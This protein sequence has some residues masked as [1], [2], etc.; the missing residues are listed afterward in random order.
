MKRLFWYGFLAACLWV[1]SS[2][3]EAPGD[4]A[5]E[6]DTSN[7]PDAGLPPQGDVDGSADA[8]GNEFDNADAVD[9]IDASLG[10][11][12][13]AAGPYGVEEGDTIADLSFVLSDGGEF[14][15]GELYNDPDAKLLLLSTTAG[16]CT[17]CI[18]EQPELQALHLAHKDQGLV[19][20]V[21][22]F[23]DIQYQPAGPSHAKQWKEAYGLDFRVVADTDFELSAY[24]DTSLTPMNMFVDL[25]TMEIIKITTGWNPTL[26]DAIINLKL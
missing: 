10:G 20:I 3:A 18:E 1:G 15:F 7:T 2:C 8:P 14:S 22:I 6:P 5:A 21:S 17:A 4:T 12:L 13:Y 26:V 9:N 16:W 25:E 19:V 23:E 11:G 24:Y